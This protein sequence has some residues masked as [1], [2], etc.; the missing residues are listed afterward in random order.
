VSKKGQRQERE[1]LVEN[2]HD[3]CLS[4]GVTLERKVVM[5]G[6]RAMRSF[7]CRVRGRGSV[8]DGEMSASTWPGNGRVDVV[9]MVWNGIDFAVRRSRW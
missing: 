7:V 8:E 9:M 3:V 2:E 4:K 6:Q 1:D 5:A